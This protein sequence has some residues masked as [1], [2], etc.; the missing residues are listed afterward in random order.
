MKKYLVFLLA[1]AFSS[2]AMAQ[3]KSGAKQ[4]L[5]ILFVG[6]SANW[7]REHFT[8]NE[9]MKQDTI[10]RIASFVEMLNKYFTSVT[11]IDA[12]DYQQK[13]SDN[14]DVT[15]FDG[16]PKAIAKSATITDASG[17][18]IGYK[19]AAYLTEDF[20]KPTVF[21]GE[22]GE[23]LGRS[24]GLKADWYCLCLDAHAHNFRKEH[25]IFKGP[26]PVKMTIETR[27]TPEDA[28]HYQYFSN[29]KY[30]A[31]LSMWQVQTKGYITDKYFRIGMVA[32]PWGFEDS[33]DA[34]YI[35]SGVCAKT[36]DAVALGRHGNFF[37][38]G[39]AASP[40][41]MTDEAQT[42]LANAIVYISKYNGKSV[43]A[44]KY[45]DRR[46]TREYLKEKKYYASKDALEMSNTI[47]ENFN[48]SMLAEK[49][50]AEAKKAKGENLTAEEKRSL[51]FQPMPKLSF[52]EF[53]KKQQGDL[54][55]K[56]GTDSKAYIKYYDD[57]KDYF[58]AFDES[59]K[60]IVDE[61]VKSL[62][63]PNYD[64][65]LLDKCI[66]MLEKNEETE[67]AKRI[68][69]RYTLAT[70]STPAE[71]RQW[72][73]KYKDK[74]FFTETGGYYFMINTYDKNVEGNDYKKK[75]QSKSYSQVKTGQTSD[76]EPVSI[77]AG[78]VDKDASEK[79][80][81][82]KMKIHP[83]Y[84]IYAFVSQTDPYIET[85]VNVSVPVGYSLSAEMK[86]PSFKYF[87]D[88]GTTI[89]DDEVMFVQDIK[90]EGKADLTCTVSY[91]C[92]DDHI[93][94]P[95]VE[96]EYKLQVL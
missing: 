40:E 85:K 17:K 82:V 47:A 9:E 16:A 76:V 66:H 63:I 73:D 41:Y 92:C 46:A 23:K 13:M 45:T 18:V 38:W 14:F 77:A 28:F 56:F 94:F 91:Q 50:D 83:G 39:F 69:D 8:S 4:N 5:K 44:R 84:H 70:F 80:V 2:I 65:R 21:I 60:I 67:K 68:L 51:D 20:D 62:G 53:L 36:L 86:K 37:H 55:Q 61:D 75:L 35:S 22:M 93:C 74:M 29:T 64:K 81:V 6:G 90:G 71:W 30:P 52:E 88:S 78:I 32:R 25:P 89:Y 58:Y 34:E 11:A 42:V 57:N 33:P 87:N 43:I 95:P 31:T 48:K 49:A 19:S 59:Y 54:F 1:V 10:R 3:S 27:P 72:F 24:I 26:F 79:Q 15:V 12:K 96:K 7:S